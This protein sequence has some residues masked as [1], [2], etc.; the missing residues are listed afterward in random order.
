[1]TLAAQQV[2]DHVATYVRAAAG[3]SASTFTDRAWSFETSE[4][5]AARVTADDEEFNGETV[6]E[7]H[8]Q[9]HDLDVLAELRVEAVDNLDDAMHDLTQAV[10]EQVH[11]SAAVAARAA[12]GVRGFRCARIRRD[13][14][15]TG[16]G[17]VGA[18][19]I[20]FRARFATLSNNPSQLR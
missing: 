6:H 2:V 15:R 4:L 13:M 11:G 14:E 10:L 16:Q 8:I 5:P 19:D 20:T 12:L 3:L 9:I 7:P 18:V 1:M 17:A